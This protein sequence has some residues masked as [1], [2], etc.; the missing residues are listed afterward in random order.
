MIEQTENAAAVGQAD[1]G[2]DSG[3]QGRPAKTHPYDFSIL[4]NLRRPRASPRP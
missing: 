4:R 1:I 3:V 2:E